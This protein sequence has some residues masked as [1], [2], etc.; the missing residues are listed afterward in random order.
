MFRSGLGRGLAAA[1]ARPRP[2]SM[3]APR[4]VV[5]RLGSP[6]ISDPALAEIMLVT[7]FLLDGYGVERDAKQCCSPFSKE[8]GR[9]PEHQSLAIV[10]STLQPRSCHHAS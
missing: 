7:S 10:E 1:A 3:Y 8:S 5:L 9:C 2:A 6:F 4:S